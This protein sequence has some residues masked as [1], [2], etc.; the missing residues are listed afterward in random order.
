MYSSAS[1]RATAS[2]T[3]TRAG[4]G[5]DGGSKTPLDPRPYR[6]A[7]RSVTRPRGGARPV[8]AFIHGPFR[9][10]IAPGHVIGRGVAR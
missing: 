10:T 4:V 6:A 1:I 7:R 5:T 8:A 2:A 9:G 3:V